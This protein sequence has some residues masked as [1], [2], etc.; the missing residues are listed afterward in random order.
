MSI[1]ICIYKYKYIS[2]GRLKNP[3]TV[4]N[5]DIFALKSFYMIKI[6]N[7]NTYMTKYI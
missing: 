2:T 6:I 7:A 5:A 3:A 1:L 4:G